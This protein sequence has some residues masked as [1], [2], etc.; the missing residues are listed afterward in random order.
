MR[1]VRWM[2][3]PRYGQQATPAE[4]LRP[5]KASALSDLAKKT[6]VRRNSGSHS[7]L[8]SFLKGLRMRK[9]GPAAL[10][11]FSSIFPCN[12]THRLS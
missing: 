2:I 11:E 9:G 3:V 5:I 6:F 8:E 12:F 10:I 4:S 1:A 7:Q